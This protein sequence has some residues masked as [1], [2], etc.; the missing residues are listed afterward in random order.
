MKFSILKISVIA[1]FTMLLVSETAWTDEIAKRNI[2]VFGLMKTHW[3]YNQAVSGDNENVFKLYNCRIGVKG[4]LND[5]TKF[6]A[7]FDFARTVNTDKFSGDMLLDGYIELSPNPWLKVKI[8]QF[9]TNFSTANLRSGS[10]LR[11]IDNPII[12]TAPPTR[13]LGMMA[14]S[15]Y[16]K[17]SMSVGFYNGNGMNEQET[18]TNKNMSLRGVWK[19][20]NSANFSANYYTGKSDDVGSSASN[21][22]RYNLGVGFNQNNFSIEGEYSS[23]DNSMQIASGYFADAQYNLKMNGFISSIVPG[24]RYGWYDTNTDTDNNAKTRYTAGLNVHF[25]KF[26]GAMIRLNY[27]INDSESDDLDDVLKTEFQLAF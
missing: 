24:F 16:D 11:F 22:T 20:I 26:T 13:D 2:K 14:E 6:K 17:F 23:Y 27:Q 1:V 3:E 18:N 21:L 9:K 15:N 5:F 7:L 4:S 19:P 10:K 8:G 12:K 25:A